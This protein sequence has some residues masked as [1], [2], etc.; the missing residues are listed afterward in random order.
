MSM[1]RIQK[2]DAE[3]IALR[4]ATKAFEHLLNPLFKKREDFGKAVYTMTLRNLGLTSEYILKLNNAGIIDDRENKYQKC[5]ILIGVEQSDDVC[6]ITLGHEF[7]I[8]GDH[9]NRGFDTQEEHNEHF[10]RIYTF[11]KLNVIDDVLYEQAEKLQEAIDPLA[12]K[13]NALK[14]T[15]AKQMAGRTCKEVMKEWPE[16]APFVIKVMKLDEKPDLMIR[17]LEELIGRFLPALPAPTGD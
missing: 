16:A 2:N 10:P 1:K 5:V 4:M 6:E 7:Y 3:N 14:A 17:P 8:W 11:N 12:K 13:G 15:L 9:F